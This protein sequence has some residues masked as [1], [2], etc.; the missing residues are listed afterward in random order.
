MSWGLCGGEGELTGY[1]LDEVSVSVFFL[2]FG[3]VVVVR[4]WI[5]FALFSLWRGWDMV[6]ERTDVGVV[7]GEEMET[8]E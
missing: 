6:E 4:I 8:S 1:A 2:L 3:V 5:L 7:C